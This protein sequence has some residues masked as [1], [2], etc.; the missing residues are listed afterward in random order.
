MEIDNFYSYFC[1]ENGFSKNIAYFLY[2]NNFSL[3]YLKYFLKLNF[4]PS[5]IACLA[6]KNASVN[7][8]RWF[9]KQ[10]YNNMYIL[11]YYLFGKV[12]IIDNF[13]IVFDN[14]KNLYNMFLSLGSFSHTQI[15]CL[16]KLSIN[17][18]DIIKLKKIGINYDE[19]FVLAMNNIDLKKV[20]HAYYLSYSQGNKYLIDDLSIFAHH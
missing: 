12:D 7:D 19:I 8:V 20:I 14:D 4:V 15:K 10:K 13:S 16:I 17:Y 6:K 3:E 11:S 18:S 5:E 1:T 9:I 2:S